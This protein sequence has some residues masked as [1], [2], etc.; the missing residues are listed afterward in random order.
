MYEQFLAHLVGDYILQ[1]HNMAIN[2][3][4]S[5]WW[6]VYH[7]IMYSLPFI[8]I[9][10]PNALFVITFTHVVI[11]RLRLANYVTKGKNYL[12]GDFN[13]QSLKEIYPQ[14]TPEYI[15]FWLVILV[16]NTMHLIINYFSILYLK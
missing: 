2:K 1:S 10:S 16:D 9:A 4:K 7:G 6:A 14:G 5:T 3:T 13:P 11:D 8:F 15:S 12:F